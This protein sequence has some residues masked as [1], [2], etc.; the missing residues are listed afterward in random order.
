MKLSRVVATFLLAMQCLASASQPTDAAGAAAPVAN[1][2]DSGPEW[3][4]WVLN[5]Q[6]CHRADGQGT[7]DSSSVLADTVARFL[8][9]PGGR[10]YL[11]QVPGVASSELS[12]EDLANLVNWMLVRFDKQHVP[13]SFA[14]YTAAEVGRLRQRPLRLEAPRIRAQLLNHANSQIVAAAR[15]KLLADK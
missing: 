1:T 9:A 12:D 8:W 3:Q 11:I 4:S 15:S 10:D 6:G 13:E 2:R 14:P 5:C 7:Q